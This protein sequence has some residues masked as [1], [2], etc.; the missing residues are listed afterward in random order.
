MAYRY[1]RFSFSVPFFSVKK[2]AMVYVVILFFS[3]RKKKRNVPVMRYRCHTPECLWGVL[4]KM[5]TMSDCQEDEEVEVED[6][7]RRE[8]DKGS[9]TRVWL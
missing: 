7:V 1:D 4:F 5:A 6:A 3:V 9:E 2:A 8:L